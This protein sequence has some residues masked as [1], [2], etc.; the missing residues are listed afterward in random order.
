MEKNPG[1]AA[2][3]SFFVPGLGQIYNGRIFDGI[4]LLVFYAISILLIFVY[5]IGLLTTPLLWLYGI[6][7]AYN[8]AIKINNGG[9][10]VNKNRSFRLTR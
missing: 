2:V 7:N 9:E 4:G 6:Y 3:L 1:L 5:G 10:E 8:G